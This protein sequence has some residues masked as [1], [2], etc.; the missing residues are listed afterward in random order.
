MEFERS[1]TFVYNEFW[2]YQRTSN[3][4]SS[5]YPR[6]GAAY[7][8]NINE[9]IYI[10]T[11]NVINKYDKNFNLI[12]QINC[13]GFNRGIYLNP[14]NQMIYVGICN[15]NTI[16][17]FDKDLNFNR[18]LTTNYNPWF[19]TGYKGQM[20]V[21]DNTNGNVYFYQ[22][23]S[24]IRTFS[25]LCNGRISSVLFDNYNQMLVL[26][27]SQPSMYIYHVNGSYTGLSMSTCSTGGRR[28]FLN[29]DS[30]GRLVIICEFKIEIF[31]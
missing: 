11:D 5:E 4:T 19:I 15:A 10:T 12:K 23:D 9:T 20:V 27:N 31:Y 1:N 24:I 16:N 18:S 26:C 6:F 29:F 13:S 8:L 28:W 7:S 30:K 25:T 14:S 21:T 22:N 17:I 2:E 3:N